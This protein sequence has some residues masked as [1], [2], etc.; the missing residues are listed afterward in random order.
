MAELAPTFR[1]LERIGEEARGLGDKLVTR[2]KELG[3]PDLCRTPPTSREAR[4][5]AD[6]ELLVADQE[7]DRLKRRIAELEARPDS[8]PL[9]T[10]A[11][12]IGY[13]MTALP[14]V[15]KNVRKGIDCAARGM[16]YYAVRPRLLVV[17]ARFSDGVIDRLQ[18]GTQLL[19]CVVD[20]GTELSLYTPEAWGDN[21]GQVFAQA[22]ALSKEAPIANPAV[23]V[24]AM[25]RLR[26]DCEEWRATM[27]CEEIPEPRRVPKAAT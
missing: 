9:P 10:I 22:M 5:I 2:A 3:H 19:Q 16:P 24:V 4:E 15:A 11:A 13:G 8:V 12:S 18:V 23:Y 21:E 27:L 14:M 6:R 7:V 26:F 20:T 17:P 25:I 1:K